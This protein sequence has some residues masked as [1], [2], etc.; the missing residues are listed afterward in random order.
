MEEE[1]TPKMRDNLTPRDRELI[2]SGRVSLAPLPPPPPE[3]TALMKLL[4]AA[5]ERRDG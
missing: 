1:V 3:R 4:Q 2:A 5:N